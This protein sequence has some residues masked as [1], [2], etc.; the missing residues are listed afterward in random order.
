M[1]E[2]FVIVNQQALWGEGFAHLVPIQLAISK[3][4]THMVNR[5]VQI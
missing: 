5:T 3:I 2:G 4:Y 1:K